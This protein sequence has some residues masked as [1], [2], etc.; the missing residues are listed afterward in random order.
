MRIF[1]ESRLNFDFRLGSFIPLRH[2]DAN[3]MSGFGGI[4][5]PKHPKVTFAQT[6]SW[7]IDSPL[8]QRQSQDLFVPKFVSGPHL[9]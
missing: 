5:D 7:R 2:F 1:A 3:V 8:V 6:K 4:S 9:L